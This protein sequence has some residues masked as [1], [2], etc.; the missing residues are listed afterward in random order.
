MGPALKALLFGSTIPIPHLTSPFHS[1]VMAASGLY[2]LPAPFVSS[3][4]Q[5][6]LLLC[7]LKT[8]YPQHTHNA[9][10]T[11]TIMMLTRAVCYRSLLTSRAL[12]RFA[13]AAVSSPPASAA[14]PAVPTLSEMTDGGP[15]LEYVVPCAPLARLNHRRVAWCQVAGGF[16]ANAESLHTREQGVLRAYADSGACGRAEVRVQ[17]L[18]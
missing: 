3:L 10:D 4:R 8:Q 11:R 16:V 5:A 1:H 2:P 17:V 12:R 7:E 9:G 6:Y 15:W 13:T 18:P 14:A